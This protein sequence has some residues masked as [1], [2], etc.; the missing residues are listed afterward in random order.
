MGQTRLSVGT[1]IRL[2]LALGEKK[3][4]I[5]FYQEFRANTIDPAGP[6]SAEVQPGDVTCQQQRKTGQ[7][8]EK[9][10]DL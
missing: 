9:R 6:I 3:Q 8:E 5:L 2:P 10:S 4:T 1:T 7:R